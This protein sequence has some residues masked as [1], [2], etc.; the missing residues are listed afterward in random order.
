MT[1]SLTT[2]EAA[3]IYKNTI[4]EKKILRLIRQK[5]VR[6]LNKLKVKSAGKEVKVIF[7][8]YWLS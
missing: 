3:S 1:F 4:G 8:L 5:L 2:H 6:S 7:N